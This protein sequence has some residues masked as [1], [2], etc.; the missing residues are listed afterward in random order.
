L[1]VRAEEYAEAD[2]EAFVRLM[3]SGLRSLGVTI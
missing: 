3:T 2:A 1:Q